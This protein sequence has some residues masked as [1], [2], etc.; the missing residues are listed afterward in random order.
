MKIRNNDPSYLRWVC[1]KSAEFDIFRLNF[2]PISSSE[3]NLS[4]QLLVG[5]VHLLAEKVLAS[6]FNGK[7]SALSLNNINV[8]SYA[9]EEVDLFFSFFG[10]DN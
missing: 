9:Q 3:F 5:F 7:E 8:S 2:S 6:R 4:F 10:S 1:R